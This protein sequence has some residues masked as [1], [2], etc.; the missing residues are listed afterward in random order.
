MEQ[1]T[2]TSEPRGSHVLSLQFIYSCG[3][4]LTYNAKME[5]IETGP[6][7]NLP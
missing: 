1:I 6:V 2:C 3:Q 5:M 7:Q 4:L